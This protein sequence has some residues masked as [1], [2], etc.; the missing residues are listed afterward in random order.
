MLRSTHVFSNRMA[1]VAALALL[2]CGQTPDEAASGGSGGNA[3]NGGNAGAGMGGSAGI[4][5]GGTAGTTNPFLCTTTGEIGEMVSVP[6]AAFSMGCATL[7]GQCENDEKPQ[8]AV[9][10]SAFDI[11]RTEVTQDAY[12]ACIQAGVCQPPSSCSW[13]CT[14]IHHPARCI[15]RSDAQAYCAWADKRLPTE[16]EWE[17]A[18]RGTD[19]RI[20][21]WGNEAA[22]CTH[23]NM[24]GCS[25]LADTVGLRPLGAS[26]YGALDMAGNVVE[27]VADWYDAGFYETSPATDPTG[28]PSGERYVGR[29]GGYKSEAVWQ[30]TSARDWYD[31]TD[32][33]G[34]MGFRCA[35]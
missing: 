2:A 33:S 7:D 26:P 5:T 31:L 28:P 19:G 1:A 10:L 35:R 13:D 3:G 23:V 12:T 22:D 11:D 6:G 17:L 15:E 27:I 18:A 16:A 32:A 20:Y 29:G 4:G 24:A 25:D 21:P 14:H 9:T 30:R 34:S 8:H